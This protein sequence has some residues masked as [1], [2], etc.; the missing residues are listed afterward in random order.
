MIE[1]LIIRWALRRLK[2]LLPKLR[3]KNY[4]VLERWGLG[5]IV[6]DSRTHEF[7]IYID[8]DL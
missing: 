2:K 8:P 7:A 4:A 6:T 5:D 1:R 3:E